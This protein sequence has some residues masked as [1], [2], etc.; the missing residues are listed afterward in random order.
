MSA[1]EEQPHGVR[2]THREEIELD[3]THDAKRLPARRENPKRRSGSEQ[4][5]K[6]ASRIGKQLLEIVENDMDALL[7]GT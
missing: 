6:R 3:L 2:L 5:G 7:T 1:L 4:L